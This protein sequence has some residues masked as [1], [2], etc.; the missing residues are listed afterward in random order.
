MAPTKSSKVIVDISSMTF[1]KILLIFAVAAFLF[2]VKDIAI[3]LFVS[4]ILAA[5]INPSV[6]WMQ[7]NK[8]PRVLGI[9]FIYVLILSALFFSFYLIIN[10]LTLEIKNL[11]KDFPVYW[12]KISTGWHEFDTF[13]KNQGWQKTIED[14]LLSLQ[15]GLASLASNFLGGIVSFIG[16]IFSFF[17]ILVMTFYLSLYDQ[18]IKKKIRS[19]LPPDKQPYFLAV[20]NRMQEKIGFWLRGQLLLSLIIFIF[21]LIGLLVLGI[22]YAWV[23]ALFAGITEFIPY[24][25]PFI[26]AIPAIFIAFTQN[27]SLG[28]YVLVLYIIIQQSE[29]NIIVPLLMKKAVGLNPVVVI[30]AMLV[31]AKIAGIAGVLLAVPVTT[32][33]GVIIGDIF[34]QSVEKDIV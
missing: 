31:G 9:V 13:S 23:L 2:Y 29:N 16:S 15:A 5:A 34:S 4:L 28:F 32:A 17:V 24:L 20:I 12:D 26:G 1:L 14:F 7:K 10:P 27:P 6:D 3:M 22:K 18:L 33:I 25:G 11:S 8:V 21:C 19:F 30:V